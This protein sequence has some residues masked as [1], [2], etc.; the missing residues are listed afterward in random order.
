M[1]HP[2]SD[3]LIHTTRDQLVERNSWKDYWGFR[4]RKSTWL[5]VTLKEP[6]YKVVLEQVQQKREL[7]IEVSCRGTLL[8]HAFSLNHI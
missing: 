6:S 2:A 5:G 3:D 8:R 4:V 7:I 1:Q